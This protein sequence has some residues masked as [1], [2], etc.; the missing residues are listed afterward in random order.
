M[1]QA[2]VLLH[3]VSFTHTAAST[4]LFTNITAHF[5][6]GWTGIVGANGAGKTTLL[7]LATGILLP[8]QGA[9]QAPADA[10]YCPQRTESV[11]ALF[12]EFLQAT[13]GEVY[14]LKGRLGIADDW[15]QRWQT[16]SHGERKRAQL[17]VALWR[18]PPVLAVDEPTNH[19]DDEAC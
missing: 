19:L 15:L 13:D 4:P 12:M 6:P 1:R 2:H 11:P 9:V 14:T 17:G 7:H 3:H 5:P 8:Q 16:L 18:Q 10:L